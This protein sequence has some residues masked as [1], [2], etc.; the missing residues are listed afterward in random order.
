MIDNVA[1]EHRKRFEF[2]IDFLIDNKIKY[3]IMR[4]YDKLPLFPNTDLDIVIEPSRYQ[5]VV[6]LILDYFLEGEFRIL[7]LVKGANS[8]AQS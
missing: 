8:L 4:G 7:S 2:F 6:S 1:N 5:E 3:V